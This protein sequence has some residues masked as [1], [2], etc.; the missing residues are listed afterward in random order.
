MSDLHQTALR[1]NVGCDAPSE[2][3]QG[4]DPS[5]IGRL[6]GEA[7]RWTEK[8]IEVHQIY[9]GRP[10]L[11]TVKSKLRAQAIFFHWGYVDITIILRNILAEAMVQGVNEA[12]M[13]LQ[14]RQLCYRL[15]ANDALV[16][17][18]IAYALNLFCLSKTG[19]PLLIYRPGGFLDFASHPIQEAALCPWMFGLAHEFGHH[20]GD[21]FKRHLTAF[22]PKIARMMGQELAA[23][24]GKNSESDR[25]LATRFMADTDFDLIAEEHIADIC[26]A[27][28]TWN[29]CGQLMLE[30][31]Q[32]SPDPQIFATEILVAHS[33][34]TLSVLMRRR[35]PNQDIRWILFGIGLR[36]ALLRFSLSGNGPVQDLLKRTGQSL[37]FL[38]TPQVAA[39]AARLSAATRVFSQGIVTAQE[40]AAALTR[41]LPAERVHQFLEWRN[42]LQTAEER[43]TVD[44]DTYGFTRMANQLGRSSAELSLMKEVVT[45]GRQNPVLEIDGVE[46]PDVDPEQGERLL[47]ELHER[48]LREGFNYK[49]DVLPG[50]PGRMVVRTSAKKSEAPEGAA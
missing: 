33:V 47:K 8:P 13:T 41:E 34:L 35:E 20:V 26:S 5:A 45:E 40:T 9:L 10:R 3:V 22:L 7:E 4:T 37:P 42:G 27:M 24:F 18:D 25:Q 30:H 1:Y 36:E 32:R 21:T 6:V 43:N 39:D 46:H 11:F 23:A 17:G 28:I 29:A 31:I 44:V 19:L 12:K 49:A 48:S 14:S 38:E 50:T 2:I 16:E 15:L